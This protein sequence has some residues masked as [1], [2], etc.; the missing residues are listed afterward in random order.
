M[1][2]TLFLLLVTLFV[3]VG[4][5]TAAPV[6]KEKALTV[7]TH[8][9]NAQGG[10]DIEL[11]DITIASSDAEPW[12]TRKATTYAIYFRGTYAPVAAGGWT[13]FDEGD[14]IYGLTTDGY[15]KKAGATASIKGFRAYFDFSGKADEVTALRFGDI[16]VGIKYLNDANDANDV[17]FNIAGQRIQKMQKGI[18]IING[19]K[20]LR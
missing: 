2:K 6:D 15:I 19:K 16:E 11:T 1:K 14:I 9:I 12:F 4:S 18:N 8:F 7:A 3:S 5:A 13:K 20:I 17:M 10:T